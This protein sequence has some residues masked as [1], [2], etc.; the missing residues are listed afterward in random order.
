MVSHRNIIIKLINSNYI[1]LLGASNRYIISNYVK[2]FVELKKEIRS[3]DIMMLEKAI[4]DAVKG[5]KKKLP[6]N[7]SNKNE[8]KSDVVTDSSNNNGV[9]SNADNNANNVAP[10]AGSEWTVIQAY[11]TIVDE[12]KAKDEELK[13]KEKKL[14]F[15]ASLDEQIKQAKVIKES[16]NSDDKQYYEYINK[17]VKKWKEDEAKKRE[18]IHHKHQKE[19][20]DRKQQIEEQNRRKFEEKEQLRLFEENNLRLAQEKIQEE[21]EKIMNWKR[22]QKE[23]LARIERENEENE[24]IR[25]IERLKEAEE[26]RR[27]MEEYA[28]KLDHEAFEREN[29]FKKRM[30]GM[31]AFAKKFENEGAGKKIRENNL[32]MEQLLLKEQKKKEESD[33]AK[34]LKKQNDAKLRT[35]RALLENEKLKQQK[36]RL[37]EQQRQEDLAF[38]K[39]Y[40]KE[41]E[42]YKQQQYENRR[43]LKEQQSNY[44]QVLSAQMDE[45]ATRHHTSK[46]G[47]EDRERELNAGTLKKI[48]EDTQMMS[49]VMHRL[50]MT[51]ARLSTAPSKM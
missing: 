48:S 30:D 6:Q 50:R 31:A 9:N 17:D 21:S 15:K 11:Q 32:M 44:R 42:E 16:N 8:V 3:D 40:Q 2:E 49:K 23:N 36:M 24:K 47:M 1:L 7:N 33:A 37:E 46:Y 41:S 28:R 26:D 20:M 19:L 14:K 18:V 25:E 13:A 22:Q 39:Y 35:Q 45:S 51:G 29:A 27:L 4:A 12:Q 10:P 34:E 38:A 43:K 5:K